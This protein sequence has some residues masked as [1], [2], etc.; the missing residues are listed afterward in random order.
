MKFKIVVPVFN[1]YPWIGKT[2]ESIEQQTCQNFDII[3]IDDA[4]TD[5]RPREIIEEFCQRN[6][7]KWKFN[8]KNQKA[9]AN[10][11]MGFAELEPKDDDVLMVIDGDDWLFNQWVL[12]DLEEIYRDPNIWLTC[13][14]PLMMRRGE[15]LKGATVPSRWVRRR[16]A[17]RKWSGFP[18]TH[19]RTF[20]FFL[21]KQIL[22]EDLCDESGAYFATA[23]DLA[24]MYPM[25]E[26]A[27]DTR[28]RYVEQVQYVY[29]DINPISDYKI[30]LR[31]QQQARKIIR[32][33]PKY[34]R[35]KSPLGT[36]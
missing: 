15:M 19:L 7:W 8:E 25:A 2:L 10:I 31:K 5:D 29:N 18:F 14:R 16:R 17:Y 13:G 4:S 26:M 34:R 24:I 35:L 11:V 36:C 22:D 20:K 33:R 30:Y 23:W 3:V 27:G 6:G 9:L 21:W 1:A 32:R 28:I 12:E